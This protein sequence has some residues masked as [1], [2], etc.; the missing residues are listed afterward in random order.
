MFNTS[1]L[2]QIVLLYG[3]IVEHIIKTL[4]F[5]RKTNV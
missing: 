5:K 4:L 3:G 1:D 2:I